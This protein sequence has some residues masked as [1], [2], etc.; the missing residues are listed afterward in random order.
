[1]ASRQD[2]FR[3]LQG[4]EEE[5]DRLFDHF[6]ASKSYLGMVAEHVW[7]P[8]TD[9]YETEQEVIVIMEIPGVSKDDVEISWHDNV[10]SVR[11]RRCDKGDHVKTCVHLMEINYG[12]FHRTIMLPFELRDDSIVDARI[13]SGF[14]RILI[15][16]PD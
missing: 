4:L 8:P 7:H 14:M 3:K 10:L 15:A 16:K 13:A 1:M 5:M 11:G 12:Q 2:I 9:V 6:F